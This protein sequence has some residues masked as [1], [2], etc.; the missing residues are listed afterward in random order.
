VG[1]HA[2][3][4]ALTAILPATANGAA[5][6]NPMFQDHA[7]LQRDIPIPV[8]GDSAPGSVVTVKLD[9][10]SRFAKADGRGHWQAVFPA[11]AADGAAHRLEASD[12][13]GESDV[14]NDILIGDVFLCGGQSNMAFTVDA[15]NNAR[16]E[17]MASKD[18]AI[19]SLTIKTRSSEVPLAHFADAAPWVPAGPE[20]TG[21]FS[22][23]CYFFARELRKTTHAPVGM[24]V[25][26]WGGSRVRAWVSTAGLSAAK[27]EQQDLGLLAKR[28]SQPDAADRGW[29]A[30][31]EQWWRARH[32]DGTAPWSPSYD[33]RQWKVAPTALGPWALWDGHSQD[34]FTGQMWLRTEV[35]LTAQQARQLAVLDLGAVNE[36]DE[37]WV[38]GQGVGGTA[39]QPSARHAIPDGVLH[40]GVNTV[41]AN[42]FCSWRYCG[43]TGPVNERA[44]RLADGTA[45]PLSQPWRYK[46][47]PAD[48]IAPQLPWGPIHGV[49]VIHNGM[50]APIGPY[51]FKGAIWYQGESDVHFAPLYQRTLAA[52]IAD[53]RRQ[54]R[55]D[56][57]FVIVQLPNFG[58]RPVR[59]VES[60]IADIREAQRRALVG[61]THADY[62]VTI[63]LGDPANI[64]PTNKQEVG[65]RLSDTVGRMLYGEDTPIGPRPASATMSERG[66]VVRFAGVSG[67]L[68]SYSGAPIA[69]ESCSATKGC[70]YV[71]ATITSRDAVRLD[72]GA[73][74]PQRIRYC[75]G[76][77]PVCNLSDASG[78][79]ASPFGI[80]V[81]AAAPKP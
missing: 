39:G 1:L 61:D 59:P 41:V 63:D 70:D 32:G 36:E 54:F 81:Q 60:E 14:A 66:V 10:V 47:M 20:T 38:N 40:P 9:S 34:G 8:Y 28:A 80:P 75:W 22:A 23:S 73:E 7:V 15:A 57:P 4:A 12:G 5:V 26:A 68:A 72:T 42:I 18:D 6:L 25:A 3:A 16:A 62:I 52:M 48:E 21:S 53:W 69:F 49:S 74:R 17:I 29:D 31:W 77:S 2:L 55:P 19:R 64:H 30:E 78:L 46:P 33:A 56:L 13:Q 58:P 71:V 35:T 27:M 65:R 51:A 79:P 45:V 37:S 67:A 44:I 11:M 76:D 50:I 24:V 43:M